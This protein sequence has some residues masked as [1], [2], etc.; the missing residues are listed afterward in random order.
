[1]DFRL[2]L[3]PSFQRVCSKFPCLQVNHIIH[4]RVQQFYPSS[5]NFLHLDFQSFPYQ[6]LFCLLELDPSQVFQIFW[7]D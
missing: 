4:S 2:C 3:L 5:Q 1:M 6:Y 7:F